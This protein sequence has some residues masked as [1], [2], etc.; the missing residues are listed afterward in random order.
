MSVM[1]K[2]YASGV[3]VPAPL[4][5]YVVVMIKWDIIVVCVLHDEREDDAGVLNEELGDMGLCG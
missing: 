3:V 5:W 2:R 1:V 4:S